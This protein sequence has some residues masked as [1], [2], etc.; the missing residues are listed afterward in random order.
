[1]IAVRLA[2]T[3]TSLVD[4]ATPPDREETWLLHARLGRIEGLLRWEGI[5]PVRAATWGGVKSRYR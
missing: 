5:V 1:M 3:Y 4:W 2:F